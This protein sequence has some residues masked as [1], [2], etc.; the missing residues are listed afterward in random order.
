[1][2]IQNLDEKM[3]SYFDEV[4][5]TICPGLIHSAKEWIVEGWNWGDDISPEQIVAAIFMEANTQKECVK[6]GDSAQEYVDTLYEVAF[7][8]LDLA[9][10]QRP[11][12]KMT[13]KMVEVVIVNRKGL[14]SYTT[15]VPFVDFS[16]LKKTVNDIIDQ[17]EF[18]KVV[19]EL[20]PN[21]DTTEEEQIEM[22]QIET[23]E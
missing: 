11:I 17:T 5:K 9:G 19:V 16:S 8:I 20:N 13:E 1:M 6:A 2:R 14:G 23:G 22:Q 10:H 18:R 21:W 3:Q 15:S 4:E 7:K 12:E